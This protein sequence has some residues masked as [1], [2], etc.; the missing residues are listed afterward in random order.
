VQEGEVIRICYGGENRMAIVGIRVL[1]VLVVGLGLPYLV[2]R[3]FRREEKMTFYT[4]QLTFLD[5]R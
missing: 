2:D 5:W 4:T 3:V 1:V